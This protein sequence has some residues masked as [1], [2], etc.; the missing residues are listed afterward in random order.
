MNVSSTYRSHVVGFSSVV[1]ILLQIPQIAPNIYWPV[2]GIMIMALLDLLPVNMS[3]PIAKYV[4]SVQDSTSIILPIGIQVHSLSEVNE[5]SFSCITVRVSSVGTFMNR[6][7]TSRHR[8]V[9]MNVRIIDYFDKVSRILDV[10]WGF[11]YDSGDYIN[12]KTVQW[13]A[14]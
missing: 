13:M 4:V 12:Q 9:G 6:L 11:V 2:L 14:C 10:R 8:L 3:D 1:S 7:T 5:V